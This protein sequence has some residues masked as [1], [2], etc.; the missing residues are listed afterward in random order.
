MRGQG[1]DG[2]L[3][4][5]DHTPRLRRLELAQASALQ[6]PGQVILRGSEHA[7]AGVYRPTR[8][9]EPYTADELEALW[10]QQ[11]GNER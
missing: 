2:D 10:T 1:I 11:R 4:E 5:R 9:G 3:T 8:A 6:I 7:E